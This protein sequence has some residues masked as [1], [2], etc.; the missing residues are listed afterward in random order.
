[1]RK[2]FFIALLVLLNGALPEPEPANAGAA[3]THYASPTGTGNGSSAAQPFKIV[4]F[5]AVA[6]AGFTLC[7]LDGVYTGSASM[8]DPPDNLRGASSNPITVRA[9]NDGKVKLDGQG[10]RAPINFYLNEWFVVEGVNAC[11]SNIDVVHIGYSSNIVI[12]RVIGWDAADRNY[13]IFSLNNGTNNLLEDIAGW[14]IGRKVIESCCN[15]DYTT[16]RR[17]WGRWEGSHVVGPKMVISLAYDNYNMTVENAIGTWSGERMKQTYT[18]LD[19]YGNPWTGNGAGTYTDYRVDQPYGIFGIDGFNKSDR[20]ARAKLLGSIAY[21]RGSDRYAPGQLVF[22][23]KVDSFQIS[24]TIGFIEPGTYANK[25]PFALYN[26]Q[27]ATGTNLSSNNLTAIGGTSSYFG[28]EWKKSSVVQGAS[29]SAVPSVFTSNSGANVCYRYEN[30]T[31]TNQPLWPW[32]MNQRIIDATVESGRAAVD[33]TKTIESMF[34]TIPAACK[35][36]TTVTPVPIVTAPT[37][38]I[39]LTVSQ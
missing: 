4:N 1:M 9:L 28:S 38:P 27:V 33:V 12:R 7:L 15:A 36:G 6:K 31:L 8:I 20:N 3:C 26:L 23:T 30:G 2:L 29:T 34:G 22:V 21:V 32:P 19:Y 16:V 25:M 18:L 17:F 14:G 13:M 35:G 5:W 37:A 11:C 24:N 39:N 10:A